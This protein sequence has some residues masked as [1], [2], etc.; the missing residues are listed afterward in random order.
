MPGLSPPPAPPLSVILATGSPAARK[1]A[2]PARQSLPRGRRVS[3][4]S[5]RPSR[6]IEPRRDRRPGE[7]AVAQRGA[8]QGE[9]GAGEAVVA[10]SYTRIVRR[11]GLA[12]PA[13]DVEPEAPGAAGWEKDAS[14]PRQSPRRAAPRQGRTGGQG[15][16]EGQAA[17]GNVGPRWRAARWRSSSTAPESCESFSGWR[18]SLGTEQRRP[19]PWDSAS[20]EERVNKRTEEAYSVLDPDTQRIR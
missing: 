2:I 5:D 6:P 16:Q 3:R 1:A 19:D 10:F 20:P 13:L 17:E 7:Y 11:P 18:D 14:Q 9:G 15:D 8:A 12:P 4:L